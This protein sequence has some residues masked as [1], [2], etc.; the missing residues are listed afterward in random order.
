MLTE[1]FDVSKW[2]NPK[3][4]NWAALKARGVK[5]MVARASYGKGLADPTFVRYAELIRANGI[6][7]SAYLFYR[8]IH[9][10]EEQLALFERQLSLVG[11]LQNGDMFPVLDMEDNQANGDGPVNGPVFSAACMK[12]ADGWRER[13]G[14]CVLYYSSFFPSHF[15]LRPEWMKGPDLYH[16]LA[17]Y[18]KEPGKPRTPYTPQWHL[19]QP[20]PRRVTEYAGGNADV[21]YDVVNPALADF[22]TLLIKLPA[23]EPSPDVIN[24]DAGTTTRPGGADLERGVDLV[25]EGVERVQC[26][27]SQR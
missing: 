1:G 24:G 11:G 7:F 10:V 15:G 14:G 18:N 8:Q 19:H 3:K 9:S 16:W 4:W 25:R 13:Y 5:F 27:T 6:V 22:D 21:D 12:I 20:R 23:E 2:Q 26:G 17:D